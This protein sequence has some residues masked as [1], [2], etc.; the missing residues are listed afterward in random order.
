MEEF[1][2]RVRWLGVY[3]AEA[4]TIDEWPMPCVN[5]P[6]RHKQPASIEERLA[7]AKEFIETVHPPFEVLVDSYVD[8]WNDP[9]LK[10]YDAW[11]ERFYVFQHV[12]EVNGQPFWN[13][14]WWN[15][16]TAL[17]GHKVDDIRKWL[18]SNIE[19]PD[20]GPKPLRR[21]T[22]E[23]LRADSNAQQIRKVFGMHDK[24]GT[25]MIEKN[26]MINLLSDLGYLPATC[27]KA[28]LE[29]DFDKSGT[30]SLEEF[31]A[32]FAA[33]HA[34]IQKQLLAQAELSHVGGPVES[35][36]AHTAAEAAQHRDRFTPSKKIL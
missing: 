11:P 24:Q 15:T 32:F 34:S 36:V 7:H 3:I 33:M 8:G 22:S 27:D 17:E 14:R 10:G 13:L 12:P 20:T 18:D 2:D 29:V 26:N 1:G 21:M 28:F 25:G 9:F 4:H 19:R 23:E 16:P 35:R 30:I 6:C 31:E 5:S